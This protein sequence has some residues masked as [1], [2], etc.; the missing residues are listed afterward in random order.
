MAKLVGLIA[1]FVTLVA[2]AMGLIFL[3]DISGLERSVSASTARF[4]GYLGTGVCL[5]LAFAVGNKAKTL[6]INRRSHD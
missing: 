6:F 1:G 5:G 3:A 2:C 4:L